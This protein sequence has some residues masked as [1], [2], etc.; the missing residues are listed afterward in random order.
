METVELFN[1]FERASLQRYIATRFKWSVVIALPCLLTTLAAIAK[2]DWD[3]P[4]LSQNFLLALSLVISFRLADDLADRQRDQLRFPNRELCKTE[5]LQSY[6]VVL[7]V[8]LAVTTALVLL[9]R[10]VIALTSLVMAICLISVWY[11]A[12]EAWQASSILNYHVVLTKYIAFVWILI[13]PDTLQNSIHGWWSA[14]TAYVLLLL[15][16]V[17]HD[18]MHRGLATAR[19]LVVIESV[20]WLAWTLWMIAEH[21]EPVFHKF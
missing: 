7:M 21:G 11:K 13:D 2:W 5:Y 15:W 9:T 19:V 6:L 8:L 1:A 14:L 16:E 17:V 10:G 12:R 20:L 3:L 4:V 18:E